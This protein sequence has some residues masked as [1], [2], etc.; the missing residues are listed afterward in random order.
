MKNNRAFTVVE[1]VLVVVIVAIIG[2]LGYLFINKSMAK[3]TSNNTSVTVTEIK[4]TSD[5]DA[6]ST[7]LDNI[8]LDSAS[9]SD[10]TTI[11]TNLN[12]F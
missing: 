3:N 8:N 4:S 11:E 7:E 5:I 1:L 10:L 9:S 12:S 2:V 6:L